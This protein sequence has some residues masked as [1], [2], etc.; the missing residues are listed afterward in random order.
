MILHLPMLSIPV[1]GNMS[2][3]CNTV[4]PIVMFDVLEQ[5]ESVDASLIFEFDFEGQENLKDST[6]DQM[7]DLGYETHNSI[8][9]L[10]TLYFVLMFYFIKVLLFSALHISRKRNN[11]LY[12]VMREQLF[13]GELL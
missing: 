12:R 8:L 2:M 5:I 10:S 13:W 3:F 9:N 6:L 11:R 1:P 7:E 4:F